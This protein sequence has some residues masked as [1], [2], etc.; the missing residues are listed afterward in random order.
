M[1]N[2]AIF[3]KI[4][5]FTAAVHQVANDFT[6]ELKLDAVTP[7]QYGILQYIAIHQPVT[8]SEI[9]DCQHISMPNTSRE[10]K[11]LYER[12]LCEKYDAPEDRR[13]QYIRLS[14]DG[15]AL[16]NEAFAHLHARFL[17]RLRDVSAEEMADIERAISLL[18]SK[19]FYVDGAAR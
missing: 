18:E 8:L 13:K 6:K 19:V 15:Q 1:D 9:S 14:P 4:V 3:Q 2:K 7:V 11:K 10:L 16:M 5:T 17:K 12:K